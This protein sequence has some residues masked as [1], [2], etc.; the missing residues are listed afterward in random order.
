[1][2]SFSTSQEELD[3][4][5]VTVAGVQM[6]PKVGRKAENLESTL[7]FIEA[8][9]DQG[10]QL[11]VLPELSNSGYVFAGRT[12]AFSLAESIPEGPSTQAWLEIAARR[13]VTIV[14][15]IAEREGER[16]AS[17]VA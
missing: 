3:F 7:G 11:I 5:L 13:N 4:P 6:K 8:A 12:E 16:L 10:A 2:S 17:I 14:A 1:M 9:A 15:G